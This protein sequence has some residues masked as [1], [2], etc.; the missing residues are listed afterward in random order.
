MRAPRLVT[1][2]AG[3]AVRYTWRTA[4]KVA[5]NTVGGCLFG[6]WW[7]RPGLVRDKT[8]E[9]LFERRAQYCAVT[10]WPPFVV[11]LTASAPGVPPWVAALS[12]RTPLGV[13]PA[14]LWGVLLT[15]FACLVIAR[16]IMASCGR[17][18]PLRRLVRDFRAHLALHRLPVALT[19]GFCLLFAFRWATGHTPALAVAY[20]IP[21]AMAMLGTVVIAHRQAVFL[22]RAE[23]LNGPLSRVLGVTEHAMEAAI[24]APGRSGDIVLTHFPPA[25]VDHLDA[26]LDAR[27]VEHLGSGASVII[28]RTMTAGVVRSIVVRS[29]VDLETSLD[30][31]VRDNTRGLI[32][33]LEPGAELPHRPDH[34]VA[35]LHPSVGPTAAADIDAA[36]MEA[37]GLRLVEWRPD[38][39]RAYIAKLGPRTAS[40]RDAL[41][42]QLVAKYPW[43]LEIGV[44]AD[45][46]G[47]RR[48][49][50]FRSPDGA[51]EK[52]VETWQAAVA[53]LSSSPLM[54]IGEGE[55]W[56]VIDEPSTGTLDLVREKDPLVEV[57]SY[58]WDTTEPTMHA[59]PFAVREDGTPMSL[60]LLEVNQLLGGV[61][62]GGKSGGITALLCGISRLHNVA[63]IGLDPKKVELAPWRRRFTRIATTEEQAT[64]VLQRLVVEMESRYDWLE[65]HGKKKFAADMF[66]PGQPLLVVV[67][68][69]LAD[70]V[71][72]AVEKEEKAEEAARATMIRRLIA[73]GRAA[74]VVVIA[75]TQ[76]PQS[77][78]VPT[79]LRDMIQLRVG[80]ATTNAAMTDTILGAGMAQNGG[81]SHEIAAT[82]RGCCYVVNETSRTP[83]RARTYWVPD[84]QVEGIAESTAPL[85][86][87][88]PWLEV[89]GQTP[90]SSDRMGEVHTEEVSFSLEDLEAI[91]AADDPAPVS[92]PVPDN[93]WA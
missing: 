43:D 13:L 10:F 26:D 91:A 32:V 53:A 69:E 75:A 12:E 22:R 17:S 73:K 90:A 47:A 50:V 56:S 79:A 93:L 2:P 31:Q 72:V 80:Y 87:P 54:A 84:E 70:L 63:L 65:Q 33:R 7:D 85:R 51:A 60:G 88:L 41:R 29:T 4:C 82:L 46:T 28:N 78:V 67:I 68:D 64:D 11:W 61:P 16:R 83:V 35:H 30:R 48:V 21:G 49:R 59:V 6:W 39:R 9:S 38:E 23:R 20:A 42:R 40:L 8:V 15:P 89:G 55:R 19:A 1:K 27:V 36:V 5:A 66:H 81:L 24:Y 77:D 92:V 37:Y 58:P 34:Q 86:V 25:V 44:K 18:W 3:W 71:S 45:L 62:G 52:R 57:Q 76:K 74:G 14:W